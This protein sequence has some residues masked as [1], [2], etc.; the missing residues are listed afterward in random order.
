MNQPE[1]PRHPAQALG[2]LD[3]GLAARLRGTLLITSRRLRAE[4][5]TDL[6][7]GQHA[8]LVRLS[9]AGPMTLGA[10][11][12]LEHVRPPSMTRTVQILIEAG[13]VERNPHPTD[14]RQVLVSVSAMGDKHIK[15]TRRRRDEWLS[16]RLASLTAAERQTLSDAEE[17]MRRIYAQ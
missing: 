11:A 16:R 10:L 7:E 1:E 15:E 9:K 13:L 3:G 14:R 2:R 8:V 17:I 5:S 12:E 6:S 4:R